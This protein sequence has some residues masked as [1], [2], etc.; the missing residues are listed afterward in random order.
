VNSC[1]AAKQKTKQDWVSLLMN[2]AP[3]RG[4]RSWWWTHICKTI[5]R[6]TCGVLSIWWWDSEQQRRRR[7]WECTVC[8]GTEIKTCWFCWVLGA[9]NGYCEKIASWRAECGLIYICWGDWKSLTCK[10]M[11]SCAQTLIQ[12]IAC[13][14]MEGVENLWKLVAV[15]CPAK[16]KTLTVMEWSLAT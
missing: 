5:S 12:F 6:L 13:R 16:S 15:S 3:H 9:L 10:I 1:V 8:T 11:W 14:E 4:A 7:R 2:E